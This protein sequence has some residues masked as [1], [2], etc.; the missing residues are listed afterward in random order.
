MTV[1]W[2]PS[3]YRDEYAEKVDALVKEKLSGGEVTTELSVPRGEVVDL[4]TALKKSVERQ[5]PP[6]ARREVGRL[7]LQRHVAVLLH[8]DPVLAGDRTAGLDAPGEYFEA[9][10]LRALE[11]VRTEA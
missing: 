2:D 7:E 1:K 3:K 6:A 9:G 4:M 5:A 8:T 10:R 11:L